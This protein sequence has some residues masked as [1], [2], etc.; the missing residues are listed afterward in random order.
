MSFAVLNASVQSLT[1]GL[2][3][4]V[5]KGCIENINTH[6]PAS[7]G[8][9]GFLRLTTWTYSLLHEA[10]RTSFSILLNF[11]PN[12][13]FEAEQAQHKKTRALVNQLRTWLYHNLGFESEREMSLRQEVSKWF[14]Q[15]CS[16]IAPTTDNHWEACFLK[17]CEDVNSLVNYCQTILSGVMN[18]AEDRE[19][20]VEAWRRKLQR[21]WPAYQFDKLV[22]DSAARFGEQINSRALRERN[23]SEWKA[24]LEAV[25]DGEDPFPYMER[26]ID[27]AVLNHLKK[28]I[29]LSG[30]DLIGELGIP[31]GPRVREGLI[32]VQQGVDE[33]VR[34]RQELLN[35]V[36][37]RM[38]GT[39]RPE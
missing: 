19:Q 13:G 23:L 7:N 25:P 21:D 37:T 33:N 3:I 18:S 1:E 38:E 28:S 10:G 31:P 35:Y 14:L 22:S 26:L 12:S 39:V 20:V 8:E 29:P 9:V 17:L 2:R 32:L 24:Y 34:G 11:P 30:K 4:H 27:A 5:D 15:T 16:A 6:P 36:K